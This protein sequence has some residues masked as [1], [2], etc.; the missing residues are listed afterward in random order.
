MSDVV[1]IM[2]ATFTSPN[3]SWHTFQSVDKCNFQILYQMN[4]LVCDA[5]I[6][7]NSQEP[8]VFF[9]LSL[10]LELCLGAYSSQ[11]RTKYIGLCAHV[12]HITDSLATVSCNLPLLCQSFDS[13]T[14]LRM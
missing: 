14:E 12:A 5:S 1:N 2:P 6:V 4:L 13:E 8:Q 9:L 11:I 7:K 10:I 3:I